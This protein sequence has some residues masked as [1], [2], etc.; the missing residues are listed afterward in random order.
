MGVVGQESQLWFNKQFSFVNL[1][2]RHKTT[3]YSVVFKNNTKIFLKLILLDQPP[4]QYHILRV[5]GQPSQGELWNQMYHLV[6]IYQIPFT[7]WP[8]SFALSRVMSGPQSGVL[9]MYCTSAGLVVVVVVVVDLL[10]FLCCFHHFSFPI[11]L[12]YYSL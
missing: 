10:L 2:A 7:C 9:V 4:F 8:Y 5:L 6:F 11:L 3:T 1:F 12:L